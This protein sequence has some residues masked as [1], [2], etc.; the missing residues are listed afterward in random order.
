MLIMQGE[1]DIQVGRPDFDGWR[2]ALVGQPRVTLRLYPALNHLFV[3]GTGSSTP[4]EYQQPAHVDAVVVDDI[5][6]WIAGL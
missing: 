1:R 2:N 3:A 6:R 5:A 4:A